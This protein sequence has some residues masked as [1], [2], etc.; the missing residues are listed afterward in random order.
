MSTKYP[1]LLDVCH[2]LAFDNLAG[3]GDPFPDKSRVYHLLLK[4]SSLL[5][6]DCSP[7]AGMYMIVMY[8]GRMIPPHGKI[9]SSEILRLIC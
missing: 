3:S 1:S 9:R 5:R 8:R 6:N 7:L 2:Q 4:D